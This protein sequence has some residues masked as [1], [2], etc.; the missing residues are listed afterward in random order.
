[1]KVGRGSGTTG[2]LMSK[3]NQIKIEKEIKQEIRRRETSDGVSFK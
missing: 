3:E 1:V 2:Y